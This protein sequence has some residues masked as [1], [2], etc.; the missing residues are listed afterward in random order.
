MDNHLSNT[1]DFSTGSGTDS[2]EQLGDTR[3]H[4]ERRTG[5]SPHHRQS[6]SLM[7][8][9]TRLGAPEVCQRVL[10]VLQY[11]ESLQLNL[12]ILLWALCWNDA[13]PDLVSNNKARF[14]RT[15]LTTSELLPGILRL[16]HH[17]PRTHNCGV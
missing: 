15:G 2:E 10:D 17:P 1:S 13:Y 4:W 16:W 8:F 6:A 11:M 9:L 3:A 7:A 5:A 14:A 12:P